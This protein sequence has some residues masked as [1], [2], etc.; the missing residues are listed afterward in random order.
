MV[1]AMPPLPSAYLGMDIGSSSAK[2]AVLVTDGFDD[3]PVQQ[4]RQGGFFLFPQSTKPPLFLSPAMPTLGEL[5]RVGRELRRSLEAV[6]PLSAIRGIALTGCGAQLLAGEWGAATLNDF[7]ALA[8]GVVAIFP[9][10]HT[11]LEMGGDSS[12]YLAVEGSPDGIGLS[13][14]DYAQNGECAAGTGSFIDQQARRLLYRVEE[15]GALVSTA[16]RAATI[17]GRCSVFAKSD[18]IHAQQRGFRPPE[19]LKGLCQAVARNFKGT[20]VHGRPLRPAVAF[21]GGVALNQGV[22]EALRAALELA[23]ES[24][25]V[26]P[27][28]AHYAAIG[29]ALVAW[30]QSQEQAPPHRPRVERESIALSSAPRLSRDQVRTMRHLE[31]KA[32]SAVTSTVD[33][34][35]GLDIGSVST[36]LA[37]LDG[38]GT[39]LMDIYTKTNAR[40]IEVVAECLAQ[41]KRSLGERITVRG[42]GTTGSGRELIGELLAADVIADEITAH[43]VGANFVADRFELPRPDTIFEIGGQDSKFIS[44]RNGVVVD[45]AMNEACAAGTGS[46]LEEQAERLGISIVEQFAKLAFAAERPL[47]LGERC[48]VFME[49][50][51]AAFLRRGVA[52]A[53]IAAGLAY[54]VAYNY[55]HRVVRNRRVGEVIFFQGGTAYN[56]AVAAALAQVVG[57]PIIVP[58]FN[59]VLGAIG[60][61]LLARDRVQATGMPSRFRGLGFEPGALRVRHFTC[62]GCAN[63]CQMQEYDFGGEK[64]YW[65]DKCTER[66][67]KPRRTEQEPRLPDLFALRQKLLMEQ[68]PECDGRGVTVGIPMA[69]YFHEQLPFWR[70]YLAFIGAHVVVSPATTRPVAELGEQLAVAEPCFPILVAHGHVA[71]LFQAGVDMVFLP[72]VINV[73]ATPDSP[74]CYLCPWGQTL[75]LV[76]VNA[77]AFEDR[78]SCILRPVV[79]FKDGPEAV[80]RALR[81]VARRLGASMR[82]SDAA[83]EAAY[84]AQASFVER[85]H[86]ATMPLV[87]THLRNGGKAVLLLGRPYNLHDPALNLAVAS[88]LRTLYGVDVIPMDALDLGGVPIGDIHQNMFWHYGQRILRAARFAAGH[89]GLQAIY[90]T[91]FKC[92]PDSYIKHFVGKALGRPYLV[93]QFDGHGNDAGMLTRC[94]AFLD[95]AGLLRRWQRQCQAV[96]ENR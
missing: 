25:F 76:V 50:D 51:I 43:A 29:C 12:R 27:F 5:A 87:E 67:R 4:M 89:T 36:N 49:K 31:A 35:L 69:M 61:A 75:P 53:D 3:A 70:T 10:V 88:K 13:I 32:P 82:Q 79:R 93:L 86:R 6:L 28:A 59:G 90:I 38:H 52:K 56:D 94:E 44:I 92:G 9:E 22:A 54:A 77:P 66:Y 85:Y 95:S 34:Y 57:K 58:P 62:K 14:I 96:G 15:I 41:V 78:E 48:T 40:P 68:T 74:E 71:A 81:Q 63:Y 65:G 24:F 60:A 91:N 23:P 83:V 42:L 73:K 64:S 46:F 16:A 55:L 72:T 8:E 47:R 19:V 37:L 30:R 84:R 80:K 2:M 20:I 1:K 39:V 18:M 11:I 7:R 26:P 21:V 45:F 17:A 33:A